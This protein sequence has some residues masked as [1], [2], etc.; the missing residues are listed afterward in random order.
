VE[1]GS[2]R[3]G[4]GAKGKNVSEPM[5]YAF[6]TPEAKSGKERSD[7]NPDPDKAPLGREV[8]RNT[9]TYH[10]G[11]RGDAQDIP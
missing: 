1:K 3:S 8:L 2:N 4:E 5:G 10:H 7:K 6:K 9:A 11:E